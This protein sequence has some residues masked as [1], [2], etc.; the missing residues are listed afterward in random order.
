MRAPAFWWPDPPLFIARLLKPFGLLYGSITAHRMRR[1]GQPPGRP[2]IC[3]GNFTAG[4]A[5]K[6]PTAIAIAE[7]LQ[8]MGVAPAFLTRGYGG[9]LRGPVLVGESEEAEITLTHVDIGD[10]ALLLAR[11]APVAVARDRRAGAQALL[12]AGVPADVFI[13][14]DGLQNPALKKALTFAVVDGETGIGNG[15]C[16]PAGPLRAPLARQLPYV[17]AL[18]VIGEGACG[19][20]VVKAGRAVGK[21]VFTARL[22]PDADAARLVRG[23][24]VFAF[25]GIG[26]PQKFFDMLT[27][28]GAEVVATKAFGDHM[29][30][31]PGQIAA[32][33]H[34]AELKGLLPVTTEK[35]A[36]R[37]S[38]LTAA[39]ALRASV[40]VV[41]V[42]LA[43]DDEDGLR[44]YLASYVS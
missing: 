35:D 38:T 21:T 40:A 12:D 41:P 15:L 34:E 17:D 44:A 7:R 27:D 24:R 13:M 36:V 22:E 29:P 4:G 33:E 8:D 5:G 30:F 3:V 11:H 9:R 6:T 1:P 43:F 28:I 16:L 14:D 39:P 26:R 20:A 19:D 25:A 10:E 18:I 2:V 32:I 37:L 23:E 42:S 31:T